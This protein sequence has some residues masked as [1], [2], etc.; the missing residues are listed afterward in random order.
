MFNLDMNEFAVQPVWLETAEHQPF[1]W[2]TNVHIQFLLSHLAIYYFPKKRWLDISD[3][4]KPDV[5]I[6]VWIASRKYTA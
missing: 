6:S 5:I 2:V 1:K 3:L 4:I